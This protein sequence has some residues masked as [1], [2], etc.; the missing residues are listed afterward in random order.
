MLFSGDSLLKTLLKQHKLIDMKKWILF[1]A[2]IVHFQPLFGQVSIGMKSGVF[3]SKLYDREYDYDSKFLLSN[4]SNLFLR[5]PIWKK[6]F[7]QLEFEYLGKGGD[8]NISPNSDNTLRIRTHQFELPILLGFKLPVK[9]LDVYGNVGMFF[10]RKTTTNILESP[11]STSSTI[12]RKYFF[13][14]KDKG[15]LFGLGAMKK[16][17]KASIL[18]EVRYRYSLDRFGRIVRL[19]QSGSFLGASD[20]N[21]NRGVSLLLGISY[22][23]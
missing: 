17:N 5:L 19:S 21:R 16:I 10:G 15:Y 7:A 14:E 3:L 9:E 22:D 4:E 18:F 13:D 11:F 8:I 2:I 12:N 23:L 6:L 1:F 20:Y